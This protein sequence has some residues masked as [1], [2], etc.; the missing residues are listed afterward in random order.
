MP[1]AVILCGGLERQ[2]VLDAPHGTAPPSEARSR[3]TLD[4]NVLHPT[5]SPWVHIVEHRLV[6]IA[7]GHTGN[8]R[9]V[10]FLVQIGHTSRIRTGSWGENNLFRWFLPLLGGIFTQLDF[11]VRLKVMKRSAKW[12]GEAWVVFEKRAADTFVVE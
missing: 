6:G 7:T 1:R 3:Y 11:N 4:D 8:R 5:L 12:T 10:V 9:N 2:V